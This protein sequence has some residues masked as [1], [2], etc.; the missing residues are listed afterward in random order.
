MKALTWRG[1]CKNGLQNLEPQGFRGQNPDNKGVAVL[2]EVAACTASALTM[3]CFLDSGVKVRCHTTCVVSV[4]FEG[5]SQVVP[6]FRKAHP[7]K[8]RRA[9][10]IFNARL[11]HDLEVSVS[12]LILIY[13]MAR[14]L[15]LALGFFA[16]ASG[17]VAFLV[18]R[19]PVSI[20]LE[21]FSVNP[22]PAD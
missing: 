22:L 2:F 14:L 20:G 7:C 17:E 1:V 12:R 6:A 18:K 13:I 21:G 10:S 15:D 8:K 3:I 16:V 9:F 19:M 11:G 4:D 5:S